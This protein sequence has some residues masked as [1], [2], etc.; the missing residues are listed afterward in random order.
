MK[1]SDDDKP[2]GMI[3]DAR[4]VRDASGKRKLV[5]DEVDPETW[6]NRRRE[7]AGWWRGARVSK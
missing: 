4:W 6:K 5:E 3:P 1:S 7:S 2:R